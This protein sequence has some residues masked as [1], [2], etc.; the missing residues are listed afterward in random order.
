MSRFA[1]SALARAACSR[2]SS[3]FRSVLEPRHLRQRHGQPLLLR[4]QRPLGCAGLRERGDGP[5]VQALDLLGVP[6]LILEPAGEELVGSISEVDR[7]HQQHGLPVIAALNDD[8]GE[9]AGGAGHHEAGAAPEEI[10]SP[11]LRTTSARDESAMAPAMRP[12]LTRK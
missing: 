10:L 5:L 6:L 9:R 8:R 2:A 11:C 3:C 12:V 1:S 7:R 4:G